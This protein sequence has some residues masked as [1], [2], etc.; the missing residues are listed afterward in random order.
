M[1]HFQQRIN[2]WKLVSGST[3]SGLAGGGLL[4]EEQNRHITAI[5]PIYCSSPHP[6]LIPGVALVTHLLFYL[7]MIVL[8]IIKNK[9]RSYYN[10]LQIC[11]YIYIKVG[12]R[13][14]WLAFQDEQIIHSLQERIK[15]PVQNLLCC[16]RSYCATEKIG[17]HQQREVSC[18]KTRLNKEQGMDHA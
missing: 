6:N 18:V 8:I 2:V 7:I 5:T 4:G 11:M 14:H 3:E 9:R 1:P 10:K 16:T 17:F 13:K 15:S 12:D